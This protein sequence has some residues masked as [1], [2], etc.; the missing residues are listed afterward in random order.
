[1][2]FWRIDIQS[3]DAVERSIAGE[4]IVTPKRISSDDLEPAAVIAQKIAKGHIVLLARFDA[5][6]QEGMVEAVGLVVDKDRTTKKP[7]LKWERVSRQ[8]SPTS[9]G[10]TQWKARAV[11]NFADAPA[12]RYG[13][14]KLAKSLFPETK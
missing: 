6:R 5:T 14:E 9:A 13:L 1:M 10:I 3:Q 8:L 4:T 12:K 11:F 2:K 7:R